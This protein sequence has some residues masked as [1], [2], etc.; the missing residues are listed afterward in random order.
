VSQSSPSRNEA[1]SAVYPNGVTLPTALV[2]RRCMAA[3]SRGL[4]TMMKL[5]ARPARL[6]VL[7]GAIQTILFCSSSGLREANGV[8]CEPFSINSQ[9]ISS[10]TTMASLARA[11]SPTAA[12]SS[13]VQ[14]RPTGLCGLHR[15]IIL[16]RDG[17]ADMPEACGRKTLFSPSRSMTYLVPFH[18][19]WLL[20]T[21]HPFSRIADQ[22][23]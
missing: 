8:W 14:T 10:E 3:R 4:G 11:I 20:A 23:G 17:E 13:R 6:N 5:V 16:T 9:C 1:S 12:S 22:N 18:S 19:S 7:D 15:M 2:I 21:W